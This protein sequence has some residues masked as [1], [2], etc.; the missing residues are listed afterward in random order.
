MD[1]AVGDVLPAL[2]LLLQMEERFVFAWIEEVRGAS[3]GLRRRARRLR[4]AGARDGE[5][6]HFGLRA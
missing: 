6:G 3:A 4:A 2:V 5:V 1:A